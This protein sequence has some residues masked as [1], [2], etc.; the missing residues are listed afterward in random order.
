MNRQ[1][2]TQDGLTVP[3]IALWSAER[4]LRMELTVRHGPAGPFLGAVDDDEDDRARN[5]YFGVLWTTYTLGRG[6]GHADL[7][8]LH[9]QRQ[10]QCMTRLLCQICGLEVDDL[11]DVLFVLR[12]RDGRPIEEGRTTEAPPLHDRCAALALRQCPVLRRGAVAARVR[13]VDTWGVSGVVY[14]L[15]TPRPEPGDLEKVHY[16]SPTLRRILASRVVS[17][18]HNVTHV[19]VRDLAALEPAAL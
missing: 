19:D 7:A 5:P 13:H 1:V 3:Y 10:Q 11:E 6:R 2:H 4:Q 12:S 9:A 17:A 15:R 16:T 8:A 18:L 14:D